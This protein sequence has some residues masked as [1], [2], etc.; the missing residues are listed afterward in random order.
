MSLTSILKYDD[1]NFKDFRSL[2]SNSFPV[3]KIEASAIK[4]VP[5]TKNYSL[6]GTA[7]DYLL[8]FNLERK[9]KAKV[10]G[11][12]WVAEN[13]LTY[14]KSRG[15]YISEDWKLSSD[16]ES[17]RDWFKARQGRNKKVLKHFDQCKEF[18][19]SFV[20]GTL[21]PS[22][23]I[24]KVCLFLAK[25]DIIYRAGP[26]YME[27]VDFLSH[28]KSDI[29]DLK[30]LISVCDYM[31]FKPKK[32]LVL[33]PTFGKGSQL[34]GGADA[35]MIIDECL[36]EIKVKKELKLK[37]TEYNQLI[38]Y[39]LLYLIGGVTGH[40]N[41]VIKNLGV[42]FAR[43]NILWTIPIK[44]IDPDDKAL[45]SAMHFLR[46]KMKKKKYREEYSL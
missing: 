22:S 25:L 23:K 5:K 3:P 28:S 34:V 13:A 41:V 35:D 40:K 6:I 16:E 31:Q 2:L 38:G 15:V 32:K 4:A 30:R 19:S 39:Y 12:P 29:D 7:F 14:F 20:R 21:R 33:N 37:R 18:Y 1:K 43:H 10:C 24:F 8:R 26:N 27:Q 11:G 9:F 44:D 42:Y 45:R 46:R 36:I 17:M